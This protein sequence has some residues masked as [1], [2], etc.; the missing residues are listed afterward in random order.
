MVIYVNIQQIG[1]RRP[2]VQAAPM[3][4]SGAPGTL[5]ELI[6]LCVEAC[7]KRHNLRAS[8]S[9]EAVLSQ[10]RIEDLAAVGGGSPSDST[11]TARWPTRRRPS[12]T[13]CRAIGTGCSA[14]S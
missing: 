1:R 10:E 7:V 12:P 9:G 8:G 2:S 4:L 5:S 11:Q 6:A 14:C 13:P 3:E